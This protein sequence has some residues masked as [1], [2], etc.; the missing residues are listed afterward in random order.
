M[1]TAFSN[2]KIQQSTQLITNTV[3]LT[4]L[5]IIIFLSQVTELDMFVKAE[6]ILPEAQGCNEPAPSCMLVVYLP[7]K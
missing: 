3:V 6:S 4:V 5:I 1:T 2:M 7:V